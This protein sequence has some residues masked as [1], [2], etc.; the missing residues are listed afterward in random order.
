MLSISMN[1]EQERRTGVPRLHIQQ[2]HVR[3]IHPK[4]TKVEKKVE[5]RRT[6]VKRYYFWFKQVFVPRRAYTN[7]S[8]ED[9]GL[10]TLATAR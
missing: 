3:R 5:K 2:P 9:V 1:R 4:L 8:P 10:S 6:H 7:I